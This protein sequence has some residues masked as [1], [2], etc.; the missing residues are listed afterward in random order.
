[1]PYDTSFYGQVNQ[2]Y[3]LDKHDLR[4]SHTT[5]SKKVLDLVILLA[6]KL[7]TQRDDTS[8]RDVC[9]KQIYTSLLISS[10]SILHEY[11]ACQE[12][13][14]LVTCY[15]TPKKPVHCNCFKKI[16]TR[17]K[18]R[19]K[20]TTSCDVCGMQWLLLHYMRI[21]KTRCSGFL[22]IHSII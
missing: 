6:G 9:L 22:C 7:E 3:V 10:C 8:I 2:L 20:C 12:S 11:C 14:V 16:R 19:H 4:D 13:A 5:R 1:M 15:C 18:S 21:C 17:N